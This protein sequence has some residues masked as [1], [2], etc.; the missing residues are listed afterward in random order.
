MTFD[1]FGDRRLLLA[2]SRL[3]GFWI[4]AGV[5]ALVL[6]LVLYREERRL[7]SRRVGLGLL[8]LRLGAAAVLVLALFE[9][10]AAE[11]F[12]T[13]L[14]GRVIVAVD[15]SESMATPDPGRSADERARLA[16]TLQLS[17]GAALDTLPRREVA[18]RLLD[19]RDAPIARIAREHAVDAFA[20][21]R[22]TTPT[23]LASL[24]DRPEATGPAR[25][26]RR[27]DDRL[28]A[29]AGRGAQGTRRRPGARRGAA[30]RRP[31][32]RPDR[33]A[34]D[35]RSP[36]SS[37]GIPVYPVLIGTTQPPRD[38]AIA[39]VKAPESV[40]KGDVASLDVTLKLD[41]Y[42]GREVAVTLDRPGASP[43]R[44]VVAAPADGSRPVVT[45]RVPMDEV[46]TVPL[47]VAIDP[48]EGDIRPDNDRRIV[49]VQVADDK[50]RVLLVDGEARWEFR[51]LR[52]AL[53]RDP[54]VAVEAVVF[55]QPENEN[56]T[57]L[58][59]SR[60]SFHPRAAR[61]G[62]GDGDGNSNRQRRIRPSPTR[63]GPSTSSLW[64]MSTRP[65]SDPRPGPGS[66][67]TL[68]E[69]AAE[70]LVLGRRP[71]ALGG[72]GGPG[73]GPQAPAG[74]RPSARRDCSRPR[75]TP[76]TRASPPACQVLADAGA[77]LAR[78][79]APGR[80]S[81][82][83]PSP[84]RAARS[85]RASPSS[86]GSSRARPSPGRPSWPGPTTPKRPRSPSSPRSRTGSARSS[87]WEPTPPGAGGTGLATS[88]TTGSG[89]RW[90]AGRPRAS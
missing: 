13:V 24:A 75:P 51:Y 61:G 59:L 19:A 46:G 62:N 22:A 76:R 36:K 32:E 42:A 79:R 66:N 73:D 14:K 4:A 72:P 38:A 29:R 55:H 9:P 80:C 68:P 71:A 53:A 58:G 47:S 28:A 56:M 17:P 49:S 88:T 90:C 64:A 1:L 35:R 10:I 37:L 69:T 6:L 30:D 5:L 23:T 77:P 74:A 82:S 8:S 45:F 26:S 50:A 89:A 52:N 12:R 43:M 16:N 65:T 84:S 86:P 7:V 63:W 78:T 83:P 11:T 67:L 31:A 85:G 27:A 39:A 57:S 60:Q 44:Q 40:Y 48:L 15:V 18:R 25:R 54:R 33:P 34:A 87:G 41:G 3:G 2:G 70:Q 20:F 81:S 21:A